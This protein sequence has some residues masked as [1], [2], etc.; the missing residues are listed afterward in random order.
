MARRAGRAIV[1]KAEP[2]A[3][4]GRAQAPKKSFTLSIQDF[5]LGL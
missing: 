2:G 5:A 3:R 4:P 1:W